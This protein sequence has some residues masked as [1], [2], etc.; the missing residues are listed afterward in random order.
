MA[1]D[2]KFHCLSLMWVLRSKKQKVII[3]TLKLYQNQDL[4]DPV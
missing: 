2:K 1:H 3:Q 4:G